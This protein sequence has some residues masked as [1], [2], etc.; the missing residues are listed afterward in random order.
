MLYVAIPNTAKWHI[1]TIINVDIGYN[2]LFFSNVDP[3]IGINVIFFLYYLTIENVILKKV[4]IG[5]M[6]FSII[7][8]FFFLV[9]FQ[10]SHSYSMFSGLFV[11]LFSDI[12]AKKIEKS[13]LYKIIQPNNDLNNNS[14]IDI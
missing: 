1:I 3:Y 14:K 13:G 12:I 10:L 6:L 11:A 2:D 7:F 4:I 5:F 8:T 9:V